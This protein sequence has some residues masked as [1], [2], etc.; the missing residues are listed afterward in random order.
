MQSTGPRISILLDNKTCCRVCSHRWSMSMFFDQN[1]RKLLCKNRVQARLCHSNLL[2]NLNI[3]EAFGLPEFTDKLVTSEKKRGPN[4]F[5]W[6]PLNC[7]QEKRI[8]R[9]ELELRLVFGAIVCRNCS[10]SLAMV[11][12]F[13]ECK[14]MTNLAHWA[15]NDFLA[16]LHATTYNN[17]FMTAIDCIFCEFVSEI[18]PLGMLLE[19]KKSL[20][21]SYIFDD[22]S[23]W[24]CRI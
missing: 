1:K 13:D 24:A 4:P 22:Y 19:H 6:G 16:K 18:D 23:S 8:C 17:C 21:L 15:K 10:L 14:E 2:P 12:H 20:E 9:G 5:T 7:W 11:H 3:M